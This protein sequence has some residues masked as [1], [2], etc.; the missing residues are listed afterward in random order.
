LF[1]PT[2]TY[3]FQFH[4]PRLHLKCT[5]PCGYLLC[6]GLEYS[7][8]VPNVLTKVFIVS[9][10][11]VS[12]IHG[13]Q[14]KHD[15]KVHLHSNR[16]L[17][18]ILTRYSTDTVFTQAESFERTPLLSLSPKQCRLDLTTTVFSNSLCRKFSKFNVEI[19]FYLKH[20]V[21]SFFYLIS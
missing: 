5:L 17:Q 15:S 12:Q 8:I 20:V 21:V 3:C 10:W 2:Y 19:V 18:S 1:I 16:M 11:W 7:F 6:I 9:W 14:D 4:T 13:T